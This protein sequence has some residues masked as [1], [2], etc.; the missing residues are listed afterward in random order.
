MTFTGLVP[1]ALDRRLDGPM[2]RDETVGRQVVEKRCRFV[3]EKRQEVLDAGRN[4]AAADVLVDAGPAR[5]ALDAIAPAAPERLARSLIERK[6]AAGQKS[7][8]RHRIQP[9]L[10]VGV[11]RADR[12]DLRIEQVE[13]V[14]QRGAHRIQIDEAAAD[15]EFARRHH[16]RHVLV[17]GEHQS[18]PQLV[19][20]ERLPLAKEERVSR[21]VL[22]RRQPVKRRRRRH[23]EDV[24]AAAGLAQA[25]Q[26]LEAL[27]HQVLVW[28]QCVVGQRL[29]V[30]QRPDC[31]RRVEIGDLVDQ[32]LRIEGV[33][34]DDDQQSPRRAQLSAGAREQQRVGGARWPGEGKARPCDRKRSRQQA[35][36]GNGGR[37]ER[38]VG[39]HGRKESAAI[40]PSV[41]R[42]QGPPNSVVIIR[43]PLPAPERA[44]P[45]PDRFATLP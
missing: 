32:A 21:D 33:S 34:R 44:F 11:E 25:K 6:L 28:R 40:G 23:H 45:C 39:A 22:R 30:G 15:R 37:G 1:E 2:Q 16:L 9:A 27:R 35:R 12:L 26:G 31:Q 24:D 8:F 3:E 7:H 18:R 4:R 38:N 43:R 14:R 19:G 20:V 36:Q 13:P 17:A 42:A 29:P 41:A 5:V 10:G